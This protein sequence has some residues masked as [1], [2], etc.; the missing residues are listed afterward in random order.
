MTEATPQGADV[1][2]TSVDSVAQAL[3]TKWESTETEEGAEEALEAVESEEVTEDIEA[4]AEEE[5]EV[6]AVAE[7]DEPDEEGAE[8]EEAEAR[9]ETLSELAEAA[10]M[11]FDEFMSQ[12]KTTAK[13]QGEQT[14]VNLADL[15]KSYQV[16]SDLTKKSMKLAEERKTWQAERESSQA[17]IN[18]DLQKTGQYLAMAQNELTREYSAIDWGKLQAE[19]PQEFLLKRQQFGERQARIEQAIEQASQHAQ[20]VLEE[21]QQA[22]AEKQ[23]EHLAQENELLLAAIPSWSDDKIRK[24]ET[25]KVAEFLESSGFSADEVATI[26]DHRIIA[27]AHK[28]MNGSEVATAADLAKKKVSKAPK[29]VK[30]NARQQVNPNEQRVKKLKGKFKGSGKVDDLAQL[31]IARGS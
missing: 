6:E 28:A 1:T 11:D 20:G 14:E 10:G 8:S 7:T 13:V 19:N 16:E 17:K 30:P 3:M 31:L 9:F 4:Q 2:G 21:Q 24:A 29:L 15:L 5:T 12:I 18:A 26:S 25:A 27:M 22:D 23:R